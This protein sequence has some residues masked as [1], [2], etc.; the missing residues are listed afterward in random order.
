MQSD[1]LSKKIVWYP[2][3]KAATQRRRHA[4]YRLGRDFTSPHAR[5]AAPHT[6]LWGGTRLVFPYHHR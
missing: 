3:A 5:W 1:H 6:P 2:T 4:H